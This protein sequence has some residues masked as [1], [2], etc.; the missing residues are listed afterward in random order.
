MFYDRGYSDIHYGTLLIS[1]DAVFNHN[2]VVITVLLP[3]LGAPI[4]PHDH[5]YVIFLNA[6]GYFLQ[7]AGYILCKNNAF[8]RK[9]FSKLPDLK[10]RHLS[11]V[12][13]WKYLF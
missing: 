4:H 1:W 3:I 12:M 13:E 5:E 7:F 8:F 9:G 6:Y 10:C 11:E 2:Y